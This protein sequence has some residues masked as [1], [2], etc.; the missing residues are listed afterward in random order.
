MK[1]KKKIKLGEFDPKCTKFPYPKQT[2]QHYLTVA[3]DN[4]VVLDENYPYIDKSF[5]FRFEY[6][7]VRF[8]LHFIVFLV[9]KIRLGLK[10][11][12]RKNIKKHK[13]LLKNGVVSVCNHVHMWDFIGIM[14][15]ILPF[16]ANIL[17][18]HKNVKGELA[19]F[20]RNVGGIPIP[21]DNLKGLKAQIKAVDNLLEN[22]GW[23]HICAE[24]SMWEYYKPIR[25]F[26]TGAA[27]YAIKNNKPILPLAFSYRKPGW[28]RRKIFHQIALFTLNV[29][30]P[31]YPNNELE[32]KQKEIEFTK[33]AH[34]EVCKL[35]GIK[36]YK[37]L[38]KPVFNNDQR[39]DY[40]ADKYGEGYKTSR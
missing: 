11:E 5:K 23:L 18:W 20:V 1:Q 40:Y 21:T 6:G 14:K 12:G 27:H 30:E 34:Q 31:I 33:R 32:G 36:S 22:G 35:A 29:G 16:K 15:A 4:G 28:I 2:D 7:F 8:L 3:K 37:N 17:V 19:W 9:A 13:E 38:Y 10:I 39:I 26:R 25:P 24:G